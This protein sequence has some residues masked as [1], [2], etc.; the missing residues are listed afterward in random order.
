MVGTTDR[1]A[2]AS[3]ADGSPHSSTAGC[4]P[5]ANS[6]SSDRDSAS[7]ELALLQQRLPAGRHRVGKLQQSQL[8]E[9]RHEPL[10]GAVVEVA[11]EPPALDVAGGDDPFA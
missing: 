2:S 3:S 7:E 1:P 5:R 9:D 11:L 8:I 6:R 10:L 4:R